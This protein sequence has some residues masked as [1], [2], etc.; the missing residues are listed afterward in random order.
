MISRGV[1]VPSLTSVVS[2]PCSRRCVGKGAAHVTRARARRLAHAEMNAA[3]EAGASTS[4][5]FRQD[6]L[7]FEDRWW[8]LGRGSTAWVEVTDGPLIAAYDRAAAAMTPS[9]PRPG[10]VRT[11][12][13][14]RQCGAS[15]DGRRGGAR[16]R[17]WLRLLG[18][19]LVPGR[20]VVPPQ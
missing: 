9:A 18:R 17:G 2:A 15:R 11:S 12:G 14:R 8:V 6:V 10:V 13:P 7:R 4:P 16:R 20:F 19:C 5:L 1:V 3:I